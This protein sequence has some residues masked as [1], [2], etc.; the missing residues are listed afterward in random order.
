M[1]VI[2]GQRKALLT[3]TSVVA[4]VV[5]TTTA[6]NILGTVSVG[7]GR[8]AVGRLE[9]FGVQRRQASIVGGDLVAEWT[10]TLAIDSRDDVVTIAIDIAQLA[11]LV[12]KA[13]V[14][15]LRRYKSEKMIVIV[16]G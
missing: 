9:A 1:F 16:V 2:L 14:T 3:S 13:K 7:H 8:L 4:F 11:L 5:A 15:R 6:I 10:S 12:A